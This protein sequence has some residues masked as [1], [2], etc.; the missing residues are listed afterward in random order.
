MR[1]WLICAIALLISNLL[2]LIKQMSRV[3]PYT[4]IIEGVRECTI[5]ER[6]REMRKKG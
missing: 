4:F 2:L 3:S 1:N 6:L 5:D